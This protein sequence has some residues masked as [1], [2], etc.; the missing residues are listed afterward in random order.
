M[1]IGYSHTRWRN[2]NDEYGIVI[3]E[4]VTAFITSIGIGLTNNTARLPSNLRKKHP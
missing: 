1:T 2:K 4:A 3:E